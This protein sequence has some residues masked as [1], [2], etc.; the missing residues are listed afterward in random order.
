MSSCFRLMAFWEL[1]ES[2]GSESLPFK[3][4]YSFIKDRPEEDMAKKQNNSGGSRFLDMFDRMEKLK[5]QNLGSECEG[6][7]EE[8]TKESKKE[9]GKFQKEKNSEKCENDVYCRNRILNNMNKF[10]RFDN[11]P[12]LV[13]YSLKQM[14]QTKKLSFLG[15]K[16]FKRNKQYQKDFK[17]R[18]KNLANCEEDFFKNEVGNEIFRNKILSERDM[19]SQENNFK[20]GKNKEKIEILQNKKRFEKENEE[21]KI[22]TQKISSFGFED[23]KISFLEFLKNEKENENLF[24]GERMWEDDSDFRTFEETGGNSPNQCFLENLLEERDSPI[25]TFLR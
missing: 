18:E 8:K 9:M 16:R 3:L 6:I 22:L 4:E 12:I 23:R 7:R 1:L 20:L 5:I 17:S 24:V 13:D 10:N 21:K 25:K 2:Q 19:N 15:K 11:Y 14:R